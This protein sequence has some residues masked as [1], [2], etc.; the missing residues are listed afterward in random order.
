[1]CASDQGPALS[2]DDLDQLLELA[3]QADADGRMPADPAWVPTYDLAWAAAEG[4]RWRAGRVASEVAWS[5]DGLTV[6][7]QQARDGALAMAATWSAR[8][9][10]AGS[11]VSVPLTAAG[12]RPRR[13]PSW[14]VNAPELDE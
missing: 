2:S 1:M 11:V 9:G 13:W 4:W 10:R 6:Q 12:Q 8:S 5:A 14:V 3:A 7:A